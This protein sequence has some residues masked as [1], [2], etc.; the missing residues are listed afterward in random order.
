MKKQKIQL[1][2]IFILIGLKSYSQNY[3]EVRIYY[4]FSKTECF[5]NSSLV[6]AISYSG[7]YLHE[8]GIK[9]L[10]YISKD[11]S[12]EPGL[13]YSIGEVIKHPGMGMPFKSKAEKMYILSISILANYTLWK[14]V[15][16]NAGLIADLQLY[17]IS[18]SSQSG[19]G[20]ETGIGG[21]YNFG[22]FLLFVNPNL[23]FH[24]LIPYKKDIH[25]IREKLFESGI[26]FGFGIKF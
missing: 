6:D 25:Q 11:F 19:I 17:S 12:I 10:R 5:S 9:Y 2:I 7:D 18:M 21:K 24:S 3:N 13:N 20:F 26:Q 8:C 15:F 4:G 16:I 14:Y 22:N 1:V 23:K